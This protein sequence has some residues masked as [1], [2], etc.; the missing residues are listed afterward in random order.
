MSLTFLY[1]NSGNGKSEYL[2]RKIA[3]MAEEMPYQHSFVVVPEQFTMSTQRALVKLAKNQVI[4]NVDVVSFERLAYRVF[5]ELG[6]HHTIM[7]ETGKSLLLRRIVGQRGD[8]LTMLKGSFRRMGTIGELKSVI[9]ELMQ[10]GI[11]PEELEAFG[12]KLAEGATLQLKLRDIVS[13]YRDFLSSFSR[14]Q[15]TA[16][17]VLEA[18]IPVLDQSKRLKDAV[19]VFDGYTGFT[20][21]QMKLLQALMGQA[22]EIYVTV[23]LD[24]REDIFGEARIE[25]LFYMS[26]KMVN[27]LRLAAREVGYPV[28]SPI[29]IPSGENSRFGANPVLTHLEQNLFRRGARAFS[30]ELN[31]RLQLFSV[32]TPREE[33]KLAAAMIR[34]LVCKEGYRYGDFAIVSGNVTGYANYAESVFSLY[35]IPYFVDTRE[36][37]L[38]H[39]LTELIRALLEMAQN[40]LS[41]DSVFRYLRTGLTGFTPEETDLLENYCIEK[42]IR[43][44]SG[45]QKRFVRPFLRHGRIREDEEG[46][47]ALLVQL[48]ALRERFLSQVSPV[49]AVLRE[50]DITVCRRCEA[51]YH[52]L[53]E[54]QVEQQ[55]L[56]SREAFEARGQEVFAAFDRQMFKLIMDLFD[57]M[58]ELLGEERMD[59]E[60]FAEILDS[61]FSVVSVATIPQGRDCVILGDIERS[62]L[63]QIKVLFFLGVNEGLIPKQS[64]GGGLLSAYDR[65]LLE[66]GD[67]ELAPGE[68]VQVFLQRFYLYLSLTKPSDALYLTY[69]RLNGEGKDMRPAYLVG[70]LQ[71]LFPELTVQN[72]A[73]NPQLF[74][75]TP[76]AGVES[77]LDGLALGDEDWALLHR[78]FCSSQAWE[79]RIGRLF[80]AHFQTYESGRLSPHLAEL[81]YGT[82]LINS[83]TRLELYAKCAFAHFLEYGL[84]LAERREFRFDSVDMG[85]LFHAILEKYGHRV[86]AE[87]G[88]T[89]VS[90]QRQEEILAEVIEEAVL[91]NP[92]ASL[93]DSARSAY[94]LERIRRIMRRSV[95]ALTQQLSRGDF[96]PAGYE[97]EFSR[98]SE[99]TPQTLMRTVGSV[100]RMDT[101]VEK[102]KVFVKVVDYKSGS[103]KFQFLSLYHGL[104]LQLVVYLNAAM[105]TMRKANPGREV[106]P[107]GI[108]Y[109]HLDDPMLEGDY[110]SEEEFFA[111]MLTRLRPNGLVNGEE[112]VYHALDKGLAPASSSAVIPLALT[113]DG[114]IAN[115]GSSAI[116]TEGLR[117]LSSYVDAMIAEQGQRMVEG[118]IAIHPYRLGNDYG[119]EYCRAKGVCGFD[120]RIPGYAYREL[121]SLTKEEILDRLCQNFDEEKEDVTAGSTDSTRE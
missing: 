92:N 29:C 110:P 91:E 57:K 51:L 11:S 81:L 53:Q 42:G 76:K 118:D 9:S 120:G 43:G 31:N 88:W 38:Y 65:S 63:D 28:A 68:R 74:A 16:E 67:L 66:E 86:E 44:L 55:L 102:D 18:L 37:V 23:T 106:I 103:T 98:V 56:Q 85:L 3:D 34:T 19:F 12:D 15:V 96:R 84:K 17:R 109:Y 32:D 60:E 95:W 87:S 4:T 105:E 64:K 71:Q 59:A 83:V 35:D 20:P 27:R 104:Q 6:M 54:L 112:S 30:G 40:N 99:L 101:W 13:I 79:E 89:A 25:D 94:V 21:V 58:V 33:L 61:G 2:F 22:K 121:E 52:F 100:D 70:S 111:D 90:P 24:V 47:Q 73:Q 108:F 46:Q 41:L 107:A 113:K 49:L 50:K 5:D 119:C 26:H 14:G 72:V 10:Y 48:N 78:W 69:A 39:P 36:Q 8:E 80:A 1:G 7:E 117:Q 93:L 75:V 116:S 82:V 45:W 114:R 97:V 62:R 77:Y 115:R